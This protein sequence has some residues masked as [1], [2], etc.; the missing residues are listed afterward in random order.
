M[1][2]IVPEGSVKDVLMSQ[3]HEKAKQTVKRASAHMALEKQSLT[4]KQIEDQIE[5][6]A[7][8]LLRD[9]PSDFW[10]AS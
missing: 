7:E 1:Y 3:A 8:E 2:A 10:E 5:R 6:L 9:R 4:S